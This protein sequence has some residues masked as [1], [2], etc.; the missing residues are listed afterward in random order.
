MDFEDD[1]ANNKSIKHVSTKKPGHW[2]DNNRWG[3]YV[4]VGDY[5]LYAVNA[6][7]NGD[8]TTDITIEDDLDKV[9]PRGSLVFATEE[10]L[11][12][13]KDTDWE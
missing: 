8:T 6:K 11:A 9:N 10:E 4:I 13:L 12:S 5:I 1:N 7:N 3:A 2:S